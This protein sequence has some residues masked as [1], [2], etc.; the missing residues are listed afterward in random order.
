MTYRD[1]VLADNPIAFWELNETSGSVVTDSVNGWQANLVG[2]VTLG[3]TGPKGGKA[4]YFDGTGYLQ[5]SN[6]TDFM[7]GAFTIEMW[8]EYDYQT[9]DYPTFIR[10]DGNGKTI[11]IRTRGPNVGRH[12]DIESYD[13]GK[14]NYMNAGVNTYTLSDWHHVAFTSSGSTQRLWVNNIENANSYE[15]GV[16]SA[17][18]TGT[19][20]PLYFGRGSGATEYFTGY[21][22]HIAIYPAAITPT[23]VYVHYYAYNNEPPA[24]PSTFSG[25]GLPL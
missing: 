4:A 14:S 25:W 11:L 22:A 3:H 2:G 1:D 8:V 21:L 5:V 23:R 6:F 17:G 9:A 24:P 20:P 7:T 15:N 19:T 10:R 13:S 12:G 18:G 16:R